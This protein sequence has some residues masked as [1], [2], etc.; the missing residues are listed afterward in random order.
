VGLVAGACFADSGNDVVCVDRDAEKLARLRKGELPL[1][2]PGL[3]ELLERNV[4][5]GRL[6]FSED[7]RAAVRGAACVFLAVETPQ[8]PDGSPELRP[9]RAAARAVGE[10]LEPQAV[11]AVKSTV[12]VGT[13]ERLQDELRAEVVSNPEF[14]KEGAA[15]EDFLRPNRVIV[16]TASPR[17]RELMA[18]LYAP[19]T[20]RNDRV[21][22]MDPRSAELTKYAANAMLATRIS[23]MNELARLS[24]HVGAD[25][26]QVRVGIGSDSRIGLSHLFPGAGFGG[27]C[28]GKDLVGLVS[29]ASGSGMELPLVRAV[30]EG[31]ERQKQVL[32]EK[33]LAHFG[34]L[35]GLHFG[36]WG[37][38]FKPNTDDVRDAPALALIEG[39]LARGARVTAYDPV[40]AETA[41]RVLGDRI[42][43]APHAW[44]AAEGADALFVVTEWNEFRRPDFDRLAALLRQKVIFDGR[45]LYEPT[46]LS[47][48][49]FT[50]Y[51][52]G[53]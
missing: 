26:E 9:L 10:W 53:R 32:L 23:F 39:L 30:R 18:E 4:R 40:A 8:G 44:A 1:Y 7:T 41:A 17:A 11:V 14:L 47:E 3:A 28:L 24:E 35:E 31:N 38:A 13:C 25:I 21:I 15:V 2:E 45:N 20:R 19:F 46:R 29:M 27:S 34:S 49:G 48:R 33:A 50:H 5:A 22:F 6:E 12:P 37:L 43:Y 51:A 16:G 42:R 36:V 52:I